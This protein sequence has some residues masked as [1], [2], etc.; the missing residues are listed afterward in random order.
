M[1]HN[2]LTTAK[3][4]D[5]IPIW[6]LYTTYNNYWRIFE[7]ED[8]NTNNFDN[9]FSSEPVNEVPA[10]TEHTPLHHPQRSRPA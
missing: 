10:Q 4:C 8:F 2:V 7:M 9:G 3:K 1:S 5:K 6:V